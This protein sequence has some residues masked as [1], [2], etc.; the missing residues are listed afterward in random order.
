MSE[1]VGVADLYRAL[2][3]EKGRVVRDN[4]GIRPRYLAV[5]K[6]E[7]LIMERAIMMDTYYGDGVGVVSYA[8]GHIVGLELL[9]AGAVLLSTGTLRLAMKGRS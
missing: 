8:P 4:G 6:D 2:H 3:L 5:T 9:D 1:V 7:R